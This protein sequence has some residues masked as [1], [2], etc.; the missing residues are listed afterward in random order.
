MILAS[1]YIADRRARERRNG[2]R[3]ATAACFR[4]RSFLFLFGYFAVEA[5]I[6]YPG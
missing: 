4:L 2:I 6:A 3:L 1:W 5:M